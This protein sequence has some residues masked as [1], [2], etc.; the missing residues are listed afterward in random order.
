ME[1]R[2]LRSLRKTFKIFNGEGEIL[3]YRTFVL[4]DPAQSCIYVRENSRHTL[5]ALQIFGGGRIRTLGELAP[6]TVFKTAA[7][8]RSATP[9]NIHSFSRLTKINIYGNIGISLT[10]QGTTALPPLHKTLRPHFE[11]LDVKIQ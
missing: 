6:T 11:H 3:P 8:N 10:F 5:P 2:S 9:P 1:L 7:F 4:R